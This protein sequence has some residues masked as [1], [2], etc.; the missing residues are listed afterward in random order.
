VLTVPYRPMIEAVA[1]VFQA[2]RAHPRRVA[3]AWLVVLGGTAVTAFGIAPLAPDAADLPRRSLTEVVPVAGLDAQL[4]ALAGHRLALHRS[5]I[6]RKNDTADSLLRRLGL[7]DPA[8]A[9]FIRQQ[10]LARVLVNGGAGKMLQAQADQHGQLVELVARFPATDPS[11]SG[12][13]FSRLTIRRTDSGFTTRLES[14]PLQTQVRLGS[15]T[16]RGSLWVAT[17]QARL[18]DAIAAQM[19]D[20]FAGDIDFHR[21]IKRGDA[22]S[23]VYETLTADDQPI[24]WNEGTGRVLA[25]E[26]RNKGRRFQALWYADPDTGRGAYYTFDGKSR[27][28]PFLASPVEFSR[29]TSGF[30]MRIHPLAKTWRVHNGVDYSAPVGTP[31]KSV[32]AGTVEFAGRQGGYGNV[33]QVRHA[34]NKSTLYAHLSR[35]D[36]RTGEAVVQGQLVGAV[37]ATGVA[38]GPHLHFEFKINGEHVDPLDVAASD[39]APTIDATERPRFVAWSSLARHK[40]SAAESMAA[41]RGD[42]E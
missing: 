2:L 24:T 8:A 29:V 16:V 27:R 1:S 4:E 14:A 10:V 25:A 21:E 38:T 20:I 34:G 17:D 33:V 36:V 13:H 41:F 32:G 3:A 39:V 12:T 30:A 37:G 22:F 42:A 35:I 40:L 9:A 11:Q 6:S 19:I 26:Y 5:T 15:A 28:K 23:V 31:V 7:N 18:P